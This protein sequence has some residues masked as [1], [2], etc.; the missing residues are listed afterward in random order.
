MPLFAGVEG[1]LEVVAS[2]RLEP[3]FDLPALWGV[4]LCLYFIFFIV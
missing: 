1:L 2:L 4:L 3:R